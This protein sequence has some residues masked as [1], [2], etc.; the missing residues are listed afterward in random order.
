M[1][2]ETTIGN[3]AKYNIH[4]NRLS[5]RILTLSLENDQILRIFHRANKTIGFISI[6]FKDSNPEY[7]D[8]EDKLNQIYIILRKIH[9]AHTEYESKSTF[10]KQ[11][12]LSE[13][14]RC[15]QRH[16]FIIEEFYNGL[17]NYDRNNKHDKNK[18]VAKL[19]DKV[20]NN[21]TQFKLTIELFKQFPMACE[22]IFVNMVR[23][24][25][26][27]YFVETNE[28]FGFF[29]F[30]RT[31]DEWLWSPPRKDDPED[32][33]FACPQTIIDQG[34]WI[35]SLLPPYIQEFIVWLDLI[36][37]NIPEKYV[38]QYKGKLG[39]EIGS[40]VEYED[41]N[42]NNNNN[43]NEDDNNNYGKDDENKEYTDER[44][45]YSDESHQ[46]RQQQQEQNQNG[47][48]CL[49]F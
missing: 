41:V 38:K 2:I 40:D 7:K 45:S 39:I 22:N 16:N 27:V 12:A 10:S 46:S 25:H 31:G 26:N 48:G 15:L 20:K 6:Y 23:L 13:Y 32:I 37:P 4:L 49:I 44:H 8:L 21:E 14:K 24:K 9:L 47:E 18:R 42:N 3:L 29:Y 43:H 30:Y 36:F 34:F 35:G 1:Y 11:N 33:W 28:I 17:K 5:K 19:P